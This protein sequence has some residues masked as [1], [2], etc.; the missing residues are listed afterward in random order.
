MV[1]IPVSFPNN[2]KK[3]IKEKA[4]AYKITQQEKIFTG[5]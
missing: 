2:L 5:I 3:R 1:Y 4:K